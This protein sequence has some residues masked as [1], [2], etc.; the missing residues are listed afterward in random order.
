MKTLPN[1]LQLACCTQMDKDGR[2]W[3]NN[4]T[5]SVAFLLYSFL[6]DDGTVGTHI[7]IYIYLVTLW[8]VVS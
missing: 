1:C 7:Y 3:P 4:D 5:D 6:L 8:Y 2:L